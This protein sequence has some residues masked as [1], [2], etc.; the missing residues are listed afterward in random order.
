MF[1]KILWAGWFAAATSS[2]STKHDA[3]TSFRT[4]SDPATDVTLAVPLTRLPIVMTRKSCPIRDE[5]IS[6]ALWED[7]QVTMNVTT[8]GGPGD[9]IEIYTDAGRLLGRGFDVEYGRKSGTA[10]A[11]CFDAGAQALRCITFDGNQAR[12]RA[13]LPVPAGLR[14]G[15]LGLRARGESDEIVLMLSGVTPAGKIH[16]LT[17][18][19]D[20][21]SW[22][23]WETISE[24]L[25]KDQTG[26]TKPAEPDK[27]KHPRKTDAADR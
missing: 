6:M 5:T 20:G 18:T 19:W 17:N 3:S 26:G 1:M 27:A 23:A 24:D 4:Q 15:Y 13:A 8:S 14:V 12:R 25:E 22:Q 2:A 16:L 7:G 9:P 21:K 10:L 11:V